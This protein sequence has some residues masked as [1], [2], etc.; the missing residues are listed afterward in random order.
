MS[1]AV[2]VFCAGR[3]RWKHRLRSLLV[4]AFSAS[5]CSIRET[6]KKA[7]HTSIEGV[8]LYDPAKHR[9]LAA[10]F[11][12][13]PRA[14]AL[15]FRALA[16]WLLGYP[17]AAFSRHRRCAQRRA[18]DRQAATMMYALAVISRTLV[19]AGNYVK[20]S[21][22]A[23]EL[24]TLAERK[25]RSVVEGVRSGRQ[26]LHHGLDRQSLGSGPSD[27]LRDHR[28]SVNRSYVFDTFILRRTWSGLYAELGQFDDAWRYIDDAMAAVDTN[29]ETWCEADIHRVAG[30]IALMSPERE[31]AKAELFFERALAVA[32]EQQAKSWELRAAMSMARLWRD[33]GKRK[34]ARELLASVYGWFTEGF[35]TLDLKQAKE[36]LDELAA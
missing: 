25:G 13:D 9:S 4:T 33:Q 29:K 32:R 3:K 26:R 1:L 24:I 18:R 19:A 35:N 7:A 16:L 17:D 10:R 22:V 15:S 31:V 28:V 30:E 6:S 36:L 8:A 14:S 11:G 27:E 21:A 20:A 34:E 2:A 12:Q 23:D 5:H